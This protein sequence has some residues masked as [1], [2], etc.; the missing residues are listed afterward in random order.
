MMLQ[1][2]Y[3]FWFIIF[4][5]SYI[6]Y[7]YYNSRNRHLFFSRGVYRALLWCS[8]LIVV[9]GILIFFSLPH[10][11]VDLSY[12]KF[13]SEEYSS[14]AG[15]QNTGE[16]GLYY[17]YLFISVFSEMNL[18][19]A[20][21]AFIVLLVWGYYIR[22]LDFYNTEKLSA[23]ALVLFLAGF[24]TLL[25]FP[26]SD[27]VHYIFDIE[28]SYNTFYNLFVYS[29]LGIGIVE[30]F[31]KILPVLVILYF[32]KEVDEP[33]DL[34]YYACF[35]ALGFA[36]IENLLYF[37]E[38]SGSIIIGRALFST[39]GHMI[40]SSIAVYGLIL[41]RFH[42]E[43]KSYLEVI[44]YFLLAAFVHA[45]YDYFLFEGFYLLF[46]ISFVFF[47]QT[48]T[49]LINNAI[50][51]SRYFDYNISFKHN[52]VKFNLA[53]HLTAVLLLDY[54]ISGLMEG[55]VTAGA[56]FIYTVIWF[57]LLIAFYISNL[58]S[59]DLYKGHWR[60]V[61]FVANN[62][63]IDSSY[64]GGNIFTSILS[65]FRANTIIPLNYEGQK[66]KLHSPRENK[67]LS[68]MLTPCGGQIIKRVKLVNSRGTKD[69]DWFLVTLN[70]PMEIVEDYEKDLILI[71]FQ[72]KYES[73]VHDIH[74]KCFLKLIPKGKKLAEESVSEDFLSYGY[75]IINGEDYEFE[76]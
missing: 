25:T 20:F 68:E 9:A 76:S 74:I 44:K 23:T 73:L 21:S 50:N 56:N 41:V 38:I 10:E 48:W 32:T 18:I 13:H 51:N 12:F 61:S 19:G 6:G 39:V 29:F 37:R 22:S 4:V 2:T 70:L 42:P 36:F 55:R 24:C 35:S 75:I 53:T 52:R 58:S 27:T 45:L 34:I 17:L 31:I 15:F 43:R 62:G 54:I 26:L 47:I 33:F 30:E 7:K 8:A 46:V 71:K 40:A 11:P 59:L 57:G 67:N 14:Y 5:G 1:L 49:I 28:Y 64:S 69:I 16:Y 60:S 65:I 66:I 63:V 3:L 72:S